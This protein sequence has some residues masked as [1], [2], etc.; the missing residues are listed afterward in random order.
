MT[1]HKQ[2]F[3]SFFLVMIYSPLYQEHLY[4]YQLFPFTAAHKP[5]SDIV[6]GTF[7]RSPAHICACARVWYRHQRRGVLWSRISRCPKLP[8]ET[9]HLLRTGG[10]VLDGRW[11]TFA[12]SSF[13]VCLCDTESRRKLRRRPCGTVCISMCE[14]VSGVVSECVSEFSDLQ[15]DW[16]HVRLFWALWLKEHGTTYLLVMCCR[17][18][19]LMSATQRS[20]KER[21]G[22]FCM[23]WKHNFKVLLCL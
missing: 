23:Y 13:F 5:A 4:E 14:C 9:L 16:P 15:V 21:A 17:E 2:I 20:T 22:T 19:P 11:D 18:M 7:I 12:C 3:F 10:A 6:L 1:A 8:C